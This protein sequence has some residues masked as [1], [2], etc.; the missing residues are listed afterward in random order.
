MRGGGGEREEVEWNLCCSHSVNSCNVAKGDTQIP[1]LSP[2]SGSLHFSLFMLKESE[3][4]KGP[5]EIWEWSEQTDWR[6]CGWG[7]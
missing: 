1:D 4:L 3:S 5:V 2:S 7:P 6:V